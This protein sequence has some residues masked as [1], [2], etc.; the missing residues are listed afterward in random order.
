MAALAEILH[1]SCFAGH[2]DTTENLLPSVL[3]VLNAGDVVSV[4][5][6]SAMQMGSIV[7]ALITLDAQASALNSNKGRKA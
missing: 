7:D 2:T 1:S 5:A 3:K 4:K 6:S